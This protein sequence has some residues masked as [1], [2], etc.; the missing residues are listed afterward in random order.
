M[1]LAWLQC[2]WARNNLYWKTYEWEQ[3]YL[4]LAFSLVAQSL[5]YEGTRTRMTTE[6]FLDFTLVQSVLLNL[7]MNQ[8]SCSCF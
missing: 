2:Q 8:P 1:D 6:Y 4:W 3:D 5:T 7:G